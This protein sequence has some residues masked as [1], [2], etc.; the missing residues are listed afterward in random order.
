M[1]HVNDEST[2]QDEELVALGMQLHD[3]AD[4]VP[5]EANESRIVSSN[6][7]PHDDVGLKIGLPVDSICRRRCPPLEVIRRCMSPSPDVVTKREKGS[8]V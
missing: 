5:A 4:F 1:R 6:I 3:V 7:F 8:H 2:G